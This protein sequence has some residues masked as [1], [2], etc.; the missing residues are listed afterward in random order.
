MDKLC[1]RIAQNAESGL[2]KFCAKTLTKVLLKNFFAHQKF[3]YTI[4]AKR[5]PAKLYDRLPG[6]NG[7]L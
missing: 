4:L 3:L 5:L 2:N 7:K 6:G 1:A